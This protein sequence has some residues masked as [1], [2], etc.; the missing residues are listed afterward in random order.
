M[1]FE[2]PEGPEIPDSL[3]FEGPDWN[4]QHQANHYQIECKARNMR[5]DS[6]KSVPAPMMFNPAR[7]EW[8]IGAPNPVEIWCA[9]PRHLPVVIES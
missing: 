7:R 5:V 6:F 1:C 9:S 2:I 3:K 8:D 4:E